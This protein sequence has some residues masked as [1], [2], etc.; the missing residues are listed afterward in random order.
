[1]LRECEALRELNVEYLEFRE[2]DRDVL[3]GGSIIQLPNMKNSVI[4]GKLKTSIGL[5]KVIGIP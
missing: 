4:R 3:Y 5:F 1:M 2:R